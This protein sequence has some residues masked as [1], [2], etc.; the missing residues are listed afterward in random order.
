MCIRPK[1]GSLWLTHLDTQKAK[2]IMFHFLQ[3][4]SIVGKAPRLDCSASCSAH[5]G[6]TSNEQL[7]NLLCSY[8]TCIVCGIDPVIIT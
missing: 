8:N 1:F 5:K 4:W 2:A 3:F 7:D 6:N